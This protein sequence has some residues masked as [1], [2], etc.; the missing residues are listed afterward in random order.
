MYAGT[1]ADRPVKD[2]G[3]AILGP[4]CF[5]GL[6][7]LLEIGFALGIARQPNSAKVADRAHSD[8]NADNGDDDE[9]LDESETSLEL[10]C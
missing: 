2:R 1:K 4:I 7:D 8:Q 9:E 3:T 10:R 6:T 5:E